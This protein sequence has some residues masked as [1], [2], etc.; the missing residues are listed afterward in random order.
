M[1]KVNY[2]TQLHTPNVNHWIL[3]FKFQPKVQHVSCNN[4]DV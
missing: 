3:S 4:V 2:E 1:P